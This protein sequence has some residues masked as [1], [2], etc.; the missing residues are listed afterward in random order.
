MKYISTRAVMGLLF[1]SLAAGQAV[2]DDDGIPRCLYSF[3]QGEEKTPIEPCAGDVRR[4]GVDARVMS[5]M[6][7]FNIPM[8]TVL[9]KSCPGGRFSAMPDG[10]DDGNRFVVKY[11][12]NVRSDYLAPIIHELGHVVQMRSAGSLAALMDGGGIRQIELGADFLAGLAFSKVLSELNY[13]QFVTNLQLVGSYKLERDD[14]GTPED[15]QA[16]FRRGAVRKYPYAELTIVEALNY[17]NVNE[18]PLFHR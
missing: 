16:A 18:Y 14:H 8:E 9:F 15:R 4:I 2:A 13:G 11:P 1:V 12:S 10:K 3:T 17:W 5:V 7:M 6:R